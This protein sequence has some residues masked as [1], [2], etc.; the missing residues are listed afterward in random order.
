MKHIVSLF[1][2]LL[3]CAILPVAV[4]FF[5][6]MAL[7][8]CFPEG[9]DSGD[10][11]LHFCLGCIPSWLFYALG[12]LGWRF[13]LITAG[14]FRKLMISHSVA[15]IGFFG[16]IFLFWSLTSMKFPDLLTVFLMSLICLIPRIAIR[17]SALIEKRMKK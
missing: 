13:H 7:P 8:L 4:A 2:H 17:I 14:F 16:L 11:L 5:I 3:F 10:I 12:L 6:A 1:V 15:V 9:Y